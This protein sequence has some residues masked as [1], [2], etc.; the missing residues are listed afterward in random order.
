MIYR[1]AT[2]EPKQDYEGHGESEGSEEGQEEVRDG[3]VVPVVQMWAGEILE[4]LL[5]LSTPLNV[6][7]LCG[8]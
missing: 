2:Q 6:A 7:A 3:S 1:Q 8:A 5:C 4:S